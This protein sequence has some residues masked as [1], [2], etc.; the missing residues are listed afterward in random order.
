MYPSHVRAIAVA[1]LL[2]AL[3]STVLAGEMARDL[4]LPIAGRAVSADGR[5]YHTQLWLMNPTDHR[6][7]VAVTY[8]RS[9]SIDPPQSISIRLPS[10]AAITRDLDEKLLGTG[11]SIGA[12]RIRAKHDVA[13]TARIYSVRRG[14]TLDHSIG[15]MLDGVSTSRA[16]ATGQRT[17]LGAVPGTPYKLYAVETAGAPMQISVRLVSAAG[18]TLGTQRF[19]LGAHASQRWEIGNGGALDAAWVEVDGVNGS[20]KCILAGESVLAESRD[21]VF[22]SMS[23]VNTPRFRISAAEMFFFIA[24]A[25]ALFGSAIAARRR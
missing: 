24:L 19:Y 13:A 21:S 8:M 14:E 18:K 2:L 7:D 16:I 10:R 12:L 9:G 20:G 23:S 5:E 22:F 6:V 4:Y 3:A 17:L 11:N 25:L 15:A 1:F